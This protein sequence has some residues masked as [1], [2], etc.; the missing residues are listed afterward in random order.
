MSLSSRLTPRDNKALHPRSPF[1]QPPT[2]PL[3]RVVDPQDIVVL[4][5]GM[6][7][8]VAAYE[9]VRSGHRVTVIEAQDRVGGR[10]KTLR[11]PFTPPLYAEAG[12]MF[13]PHH[14]TLTIGYSTKFGLTLK[15]VDIVP[16]MYYVGEQRIP[17]P[18]DPKA[19]WPYELTPDEQQGGLKGLWGKYLIPP[20]MQGFGDP[21]APHWPPSRLKGLAGMTFTDYL[22][23]QGA[24]PGAVEL[25]ALGYFNA[26]GDGAAWAA[27]L[28][29][30]R[31][32][33]LTTDCCPPELFFHVAPVD[34]S[35]PRDQQAIASDTEEIVSATPAND[36][37]TLQIAGGND[38]LAKAFADS[39]ELKDRIKLRTVVRGIEWDDKGVKIH[40]DGPNGPVTVPAERA[41]CTIPFSVLRDIDLNGPLSIP[42]RRAIMR[43]EYASVT[44]TYVES[45]TRFWE[46][47][48]LPP[49]VI[50]DLP[51]MLI[52]HQ[53]A[54]QD[55]PRA[56]LESY[57]SGANAR[58]YAA[59]SDKDTISDIETTI[60]AIY[61]VAP[62]IFEKATRFSWDDEPYAKGGYAWFL[63]GD[64]G[65][66]LPTIAQPEGRLHFAGEHTSVMPGWIQ[67]ALESG[68]RAADEVIGAEMPGLTA[69]Q[70]PW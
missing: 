3:A 15:P 18:N 12:A 53:T 57:A 49:T 1:P 66:L 22:A 16:S 65:V 34:R 10:V 32:L 24:S 20:I 40:C 48:K 55:G 46:P 45:A 43:L 28:L 26:W 67:G 62:T 25:M 17:D 23:Q 8:L 60:A 36:A 52:N 41:I 63:P 33:C 38:L 64:M 61:G 19:P 58:V 68:L 6:A 54:A 70:L 47:L 30:L 21:R 31:D 9:L 35:T 7:G 42:K 2:E 44:R 59:Q 29:L 5:A 27:A 39:P 14:H 11:D 4:G 56:I 51:A 13:L 37:S 50:T 69:A